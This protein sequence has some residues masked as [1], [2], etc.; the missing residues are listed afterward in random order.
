MSLFWGGEVVGRIWAAQQPK[1]A[2]YFAENTFHFASFTRNL[3]A[4][5][6]EQTYIVSNTV[7]GRNPERLQKYFILFVLRGFT[8]PRWCRVSSCVLHYN[9]YPSYKSTIINSES[10]VSIDQ[11]IQS[12][13]L[14]YPHL[15]IPLD[16]S[17]RTTTKSKN[18]WQFSGIF[19]FWYLIISFLLID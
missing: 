4:T 11:T 12:N 5:Y 16:V 7:D 15:T 3:G 18:L 1:V 10:I 19:S 6:F 17:G 9:M 13:T 14:M 8:H 2:K